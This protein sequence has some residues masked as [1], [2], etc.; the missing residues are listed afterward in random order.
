MSFVQALAV[1]W[2]NIFTSPRVWA[3]IITHATSVFGY[4]TVVNQLPTYMKYILAFNIKEVTVHSQA[5]TYL[6][7]VQLLVGIWYNICRYLEAPLM[8][9]SN[10]GAQIV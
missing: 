5:V 10:N 3:I 9:T 6:I 7:N 4:F 2:K 8:Y 1:P